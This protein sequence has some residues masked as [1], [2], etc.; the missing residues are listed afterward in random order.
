MLDKNN[1]PHCVLVVIVYAVDSWCSSETDIIILVYMNTFIL[2]DHK[3]AV[4]QNAV[5][6]EIQFMCK[7]KFPVTRLNLN[8]PEMK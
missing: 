4:Q 2:S 7:R 3:T 6:L 5:Q 1:T 8:E